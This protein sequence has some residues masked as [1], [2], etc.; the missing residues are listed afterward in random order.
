MS[1]CQ[2]NTKASELIDLYAF[3]DEQGRTRLLD[4]LIRDGT[5]FH[6]GIDWHTH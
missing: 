4:V 1:D 3:L 2:L 5:Y 6:A